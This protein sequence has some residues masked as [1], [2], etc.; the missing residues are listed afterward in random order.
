MIRTARVSSPLG[1]AGM[2]LLR[3]ALA[4]GAMLLMLGAMLLGLVLASG[5]LLW[6]L[7]RGRRPPAM[8]M[9]WGQAAVR[10]G[11]Q[12]PPAGEVVDVQAREVDPGRIR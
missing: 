1:R 10:R 7:V 6:A 2:A 9:R 4:I 5:L 3:T 8:N 11:F 12:R